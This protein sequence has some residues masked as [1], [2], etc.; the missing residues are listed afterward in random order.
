MTDRYLYV[1]QATCKETR[2]T[3]GH[4]HELPDYCLTLALIL[5]INSNYPKNQYPKGKQKKY[6]ITCKIIS[7]ET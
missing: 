6:L 7:M 2:S 4:S 1:L 5:Q 3:F